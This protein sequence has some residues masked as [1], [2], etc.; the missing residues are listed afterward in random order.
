M[1][2]ERQKGRGS[3]TA[4]SGNMRGREERGKEE[5]MTN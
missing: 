1:Q 4:M 3:M 5:I 2:E